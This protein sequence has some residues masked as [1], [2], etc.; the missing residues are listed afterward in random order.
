MHQSKRCHDN[1]LQNFKSKHLDPILLTKFGCLFCTAGAKIRISQ[2]LKKNKSCQQKFLSKFKVRNIEELLPLLESLRRR[3]RNSRSRVSRNLENK[4]QK[5]KKKASDESNVKTDFELLNSFRRDTSFANVRLCVKCGQ[6]ICRGEIFSHEEL[7]IDPGEIL[8]KRRFESYFRCKDCKDGEKLINSKARVTIEVLP[9]EDRTILLPSSRLPANADPTD[10]D[11]NSKP[12][13][14]LFPASLEALDHNSETS[15]TCKSRYMDSGIMYKFDPVVLDVASIAYE[16]ELNKYKMIQKS[17]DRFQGV[18]KEGEDNILES[19]DK[20]TNDHVLVGSRSWEKVEKDLSLHRIEQ[21]GTFCLSLTVPLPCQEDVLASCL[22]QSGVVVSVEYVGSS[23]SE[24]DTIYYVHNHLA[25]FDCDRSC[26][27]VKLEEYLPGL[28]D[29]RSIPTKFLATILTSTQLKMASF[30]K[31]FLKENCSNIHSEDY[32]LKLKYDLDGT[33][34]L[35]GFIWP[36]QLDQ[37]NIGIANYPS[38]PVDPEQKLSALKFIDSTISTSTNSATLQAQFGLSKHESGKLANLAKQF[39]YHRCQQNDCKTCNTVRL[40]CVFTDFTVSPAPE[41]RQNIATA[42]RFRE[43]VFNSLKSTSEDDTRSLETFEWL[44]RLFSSVGGDI[45]ESNGSRIWEIEFGT[46]SLQMLI[47]K[48]LLDLTG[49]YPH[50]PMIALYHY[51]LT[52][53]EDNFQVVMKTDRLCDTFSKP[54]HIGLL[55]A[56]KSEIEVVPGNGFKIVR[57]QNFER[58]NFN[59]EE[60]L[61]DSLK[62]SHREISL[63]ESFSLLDKTIQRT[64][65]STSSEYICAYLERKVYFKKINIESEGSFKIVGAPGFYERQRSNIDKYFSRRNGNH[66]T[67]LEFVAHYDFMGSEQSRQINK[68]FSRTEEVSIN[69]SETISAFDPDRK[70]PELI[71]TT[72]GEV[73]RMRSSKKIVS[74][75]KFEDDIMKIRYSKVLMFFPTDSEIR[76]E[77]KINEYF[78]KRDTTGDKDSTG[79]TI[80]SRVER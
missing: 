9:S 46:E 64:M 15:A 49:K 18:I 55:K 48:R 72:A 25:S 69:D 2:H 50:D 74:Y 56:F 41:F 20:V 23:T 43:L 44:Q 33:I 3:M 45:I 1:Y 67:L 77:D 19:V 11:I 42:S 79:L 52:C 14:C 57:D 5:E 34:S 73:M 17:S 58:S 68:L 54:Y 36:K 39:Q 53:S 47:D 29:L 28:L 78:F 27:K 13:T 35:V 22:V 16:N 37:I 59:E 63:G 66:V 32:S 12:I 51:C 76:E 61:V 31:H 75:P 71:F 30:V 10:Y 6:N 65:N 7:Q 24:L 80:V 40:P 4:K 62:T 70:L 26:S 8:E 60:S 38:L 21:F